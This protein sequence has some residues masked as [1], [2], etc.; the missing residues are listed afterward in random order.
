MPVYIEGCG[1]G[2]TTPNPVESN[3]GGCLRQVPADTGGPGV[4]SAG[5]AAEASEAAGGARRTG[6]AE[7]GAGGP[8]RRRAEHQQGGA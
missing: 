8:P 4:P 5:G 1:I 7:R 6:G 3:L 2:L